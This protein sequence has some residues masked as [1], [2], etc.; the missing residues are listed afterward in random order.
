MPAGG[1]SG[2]DCCPAAR[3]ARKRLLQGLYF[4]PYM[5]TMYQEKNYA[6][7]IR[8]DDGRIARRYSAIDPA[9]TAVRCTCGRAECHRGRLLP[10]RE[11]VAELYRVILKI[12]EEEIAVCEPSHWASVLYALR[13]A[14]SIEDVEADT[15]YVEDPMVFALCEPTVDYERGQSEMA[16]KYVAASTFFNFIW[17]A[18]EAS[19]SE[20]AAGELNRLAKEQRY[21]ERGRRLLE[22]RSELSSRFRGTGDLVKLALLQC[23]KGGRMD[24]RCDNVEGKYGNTT[25]IAAAELAREFRN[26]LFHGGDESPGHEDWG[27]VVTSRCRIYRFYSVSLLLLYLIQ[28]MCWIE[29]QDLEETFEYGSDSKELTACQIFERLQFKGPGI[30]PPLQAETMG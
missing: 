4:V 22:A 19:V 6:K 9:E 10:I 7:W 1:C 24:D 16:S 23:R 3:Q 30:W 25:L 8:G 2:A 15:G 14:A 21:G 28:A 17:Q 18:Y 13:M 29:H 5:Y 20:T 12:D 11:H 26:F 27:D